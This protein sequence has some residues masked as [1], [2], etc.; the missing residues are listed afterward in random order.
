M[1]VGPCLTEINVIIAR[2]LLW[3][4]VQDLSYL[5]DSFCIRLLMVCSRQEVF[6]ST[7]PSKIDMLVKLKITY[8]PS[9]SP[10]FLSFCF[11]FYNI[12]S[13]LY[14]SMDTSNNTQRT[15]CLR[16]EHKTCNM[17]KCGRREFAMW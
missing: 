7:F 16:K 15:Q 3:V 12:L 9:H 14:V 11:S 8:P 1:W 13:L 10:L 2:G 4:S 5:P 6:L 17:V